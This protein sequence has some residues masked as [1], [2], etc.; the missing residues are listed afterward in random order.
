M[1]SDIWTKKFKLRYGNVT[2]NFGVESVI[3]ELSGYIRGF[4][5]VFLLTSKRA[6]MVSGALDDVSRILN[7]QGI[8]YIL[9]DK[10]TPN[11]STSLVE[12][13]VEYA[14][15]HSVDL[16]IAIGGGSV[17]DTAKAV[18]LVLSTGIGIVDLMKNNIHYVNHVNI[19]LIAINLTHGTGSEI[20]RYAVLTISG[21]IEKRGF[22]AIYPN[23]SFDDPK[24]TITLSRDQTIY[25]SL[26]AF[27]H[28]YESATS[29]Y[30]NAFVNTL[31][32]K[33]VENIVE[34]LPM[35][36]DRPG[37]IILR[38]KLLYASMLSGICI[39]LA[40]T[41]LNH[42]LEHGLTGLKPSLPHGA[43][44]AITGPLVIYY[45][46][47]AMPHS[48]ARILKLLDPSI[49]PLSEDAWKAANSVKRFQEMLGFHEKL[50]DY[51][52]E[53]RD[54]G[55]VMEFVERMI[56]ERYRGIP[57]EVT[58]DILKNILYNSL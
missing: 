57:F 29:L 14:K 27:Y 19:P 50:S 13:A 20:N 48:S 37:D 7:E 2:L 9:F 44:L 22:N 25:T 30:S 17:I 55:K 28:A 6:A 53:K 35:V 42:A 41:H 32:E 24:Y 33:S 47:K 45:T 38:S 52:I 1:E 26:D 12:E 34:A 31:A 16:L 39:D 49:K 54:L 10:V 43:G 36:L 15:A 11:P 3:E 8:E 21:T 46:H 58:R 18:S 4:K 5:K 51:G 40:M 56:R 23:V